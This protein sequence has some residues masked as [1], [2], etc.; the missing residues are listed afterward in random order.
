VYF[1]TAS[2]ADFDVA[3]VVSASA[4]VLSLSVAVSSSDS[5]EE[6]EEED[7]DAGFSSF[8]DDFDEDEDDDDFDEAIGDTLTVPAGAVPAMFMNPTVLENPPRICTATNPTPAKTAN[9]VMAAYRLVFTASAT[10]CFRLLLLLL[11]GA[12]SSARSTSNNGCR[13]FAILIRTLWRVGAT[14]FHFFINFVC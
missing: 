13:S 4:S 11:L 1:T 2:P 6:D 7:D 3:V 14:T 8:P 9:V 10:G 12:P 5:D